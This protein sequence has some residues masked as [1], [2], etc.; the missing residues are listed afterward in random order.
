MNRREFL[1]YLGLG[2]TVLLIDPK[3]LIAS[4]PVL[5][6]SRQYPKLYF[7]GF[8]RSPTNT[9]LAGQFLWMVEWVAED[10]EAGR[11]HWFS[12]IT[13][14]EYA[15]RQARYPEQYVRTS[16]QNG[17]LSVVH[18]MDQIISDAE[19]GIVQTG[20]R[21]Q[22]PNPDFNPDLPATTEWDD[23]YEVWNPAVINGDPVMKKIRSMKFAAFDENEPDAWD[24]EKHAA[25]ACAML[26][27]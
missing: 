2:S 14:S 5:D 13:I 6:I 21:H 8:K 23:E 7:T 10:G 11:T 9:I 22:I 26:K 1:S 15:L 19:K 16:M 25:I 27:L 24:F 20:Q 18:Y 17:T 4:D 3:S 12:T